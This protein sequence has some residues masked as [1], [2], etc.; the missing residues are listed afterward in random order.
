[1]QV[2]LH[3]KGSSVAVAS[4]WRTEP[5]RWSIAQPESPLPLQ[6]FY[7]LLS[8]FHPRWKPWYLFHDRTPKFV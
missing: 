1:M 6:L 7:V 3:D 2:A 8:N 5:R 4:V